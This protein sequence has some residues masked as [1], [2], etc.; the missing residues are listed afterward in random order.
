GSRRRRRADPPPDLIHCGRVATD[1]PGLDFVAFVHDQVVSHLLPASGTVTI[2][3]DA[4]SDIRLDHPS[5]SRQH[6]ILH[7]GPP[8][9]IEDLG[10]ANGTLV[11]GRPAVGAE[12]E[13]QRLWSA[14]NRPVEL[15]LGGRLVFGFVAAVIRPAPL[16]AAP[17]SGAGVNP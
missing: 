2:G 8:L 12:S 9:R 15:A 17:R 4:A 3:R 5:V 1:P 10:S 11:G 16:S 6:A 14:P 13:T 7:V